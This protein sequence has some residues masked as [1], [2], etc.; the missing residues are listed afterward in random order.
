MRIVLPDGT[1]GATK[2]RIAHIRFTVNASTCLATGRDSGPLGV[3]GMFSGSG[4]ITTS[5]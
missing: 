1:I 3:V 4:K 2:W 5:G